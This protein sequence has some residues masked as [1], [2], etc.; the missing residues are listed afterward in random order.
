MLTGNNKYSNEATAQLGSG[1]TQLYTW[2]QFWTELFANIPQDKTVSNK[3]LVKIEIWYFLCTF[4]LWNQNIQSTLYA[5]FFSIFKHYA[6]FF[7]SLSCLF[8]EC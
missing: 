3:D 5:R 6:L 4:R 8:F 1:G 2:L 7:L